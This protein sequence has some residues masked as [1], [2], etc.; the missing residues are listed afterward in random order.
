M[1]PQLEHILGIGRIQEQFDLFPFLSMRLHTKAEYFFEAK[2]KQD[3]LASIQAADKLKIPLVMLGGGSNLVFHASHVDGLV[4]KNSYSDMHIVS[5]T[6][7][8]IDIEV[9]GGMN[10]ALLIQ[11]LEEKG[12]SGLEY[13]KG[14]PGTVGGG[15]YM[16]SKWTHPVSYVGD[17]VQ[18][19][20]LAD[21]K[22]IEK[23]VDRA[24]F[25]FA[26][27]YSK[28]QDTHEYVISV[29]FHLEKLDSKL[30]T[31]RALNAQA[32]R[33]KTQPF[34]KPTCGC[35]FRNISEDTQK[36]YNL[37]TKSAGYLIDQAGLKGTTIGSFTVSSAHAN[38]IQN[39][40]VGEARPEDLKKLAELIKEKVKAKFNIQLE[41]EV[42]IM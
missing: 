18:S 28:L 6:E 27:D 25:E 29:V 13:Q 9:G 38:F 35:F 37:P 14:L 4:V 21:G 5:E 31:E 26:Y 23:K 15:V 41:E 12:Y 24:Y 11:H 1:K 42:Q 40:G 30:V 16:N 3:L 39:T 7:K 17:C 36:K 22:G 33:H 34:G 8:D 10:M 2:T 19:A 32:Y 20:I